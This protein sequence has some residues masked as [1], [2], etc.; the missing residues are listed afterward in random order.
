[1]FSDEK[2]NKL[3]NL[4]DNIKKVYTEILD[5]T[6]VKI[7][8]TVFENPITSKMA[9]DLKVAVSLLPV[10]NNDE[11]V[12]I[13][14]IDAIELVIGTDLKPQFFK[15]YDPELTKIGNCTYIPSLSTVFIVPKSRCTVTRDVLLRD[16]VPLCKQFKII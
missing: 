10:M 1:E 5:F 3:K 2:Y 11:S 7:T 9:F 4:I 16:F 14:L 15:K 13:Q 8:V 12:T 6:K